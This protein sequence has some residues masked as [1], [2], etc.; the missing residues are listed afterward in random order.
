MGE[1]DGVEKGG[2][3][4]KGGMLEDEVGNVSRVVE[5]KNS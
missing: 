2:E 3:V 1:D 5:W 4:G